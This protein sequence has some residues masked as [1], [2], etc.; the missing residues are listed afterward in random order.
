MN[1]PSKAKVLDL[2]VNGPR[3]HK[4]KWK[5]IGGSYVW[6]K[7]MLN[8]LWIGICGAHSSSY[9]ARAYREADW[10]TTS[11]WKKVTCLRCLSKRTK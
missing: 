5:K 6:D 1:N 2:L 4:S 10:K 3:I 11:S 9:T 8:C 7:S